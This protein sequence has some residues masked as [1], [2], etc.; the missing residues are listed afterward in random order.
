MA[1]QFPQS[2]RRRQSRS[3][4]ATLLSL[5]F[6]RHAR[7]KRLLI[8]LIAI[9]LT[10]LWLDHDRQEQ[11]KMA[12]MGV[13]KT[14][15]SGPSHWLRHWRNPGFMLGYSEWRRNALWVTYRLSQKPQRH[16]GQRPKHFTIDNRSLMRIAS[17]DYTRSGYDRGHLAPN[18]AIASEYGRSAQLASFK[19]SNISP[20][21]KNLNQK[22]WQRLEEVVVDHFLPRQQTLW[23]IT[24]PIF[25]EQI[26]SLRSGV[27]IPDAF[28]KIIVKPASDTE[29]AEAISFVMPQQVKGNEPLS[30]FLS[31][32]DEIETATGLDFFHQLEDKAEKRLEAATSDG[33]A[34]NLAAVDNTP[35]RY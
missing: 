3:L 31:S 34:W 14:T 1:F 8:L 23:V 26:S 33:S 29:P 2:S 12:Y 24:G 22:L 5:F 15:E 32:I 16:S 25:D 4:L 9:P 7:G 6:S 27:E 13:P 30:R 17:N 28:Y 10:F 11:A 35:A 18:Y 21:R 19:M 20:Q